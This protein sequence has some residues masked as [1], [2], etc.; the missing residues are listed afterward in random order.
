MKHRRSQ[1]LI[2]IVNALEEDGERSFGE[3]RTRNGFDV[4]MH[5]ALLIV[6]FHVIQACE[7]SLDRYSIALR[8]RIIYS[9]PSVQRQYVRFA[10]LSFQSDMQRI[11]KDRIAINLY[12]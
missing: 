4:L 3:F 1:Q 12:L 8:S 7:R 2:S 11:R 10:I 5:C 9:L 6:I